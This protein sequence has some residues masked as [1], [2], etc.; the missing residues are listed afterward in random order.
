M[1]QKV[2]IVSEKRITEMCFMLTVVSEVV[3]EER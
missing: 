3:R 1:K 2:N